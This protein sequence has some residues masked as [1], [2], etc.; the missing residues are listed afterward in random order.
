MHY[1]ATDEKTGLAFS[2]W[3]GSNEESFSIYTL[4]LQVMYRGVAV[5]LGGKESG[6]GQTMGP[7]SRPLDILVISSHR[8]TNVIHGTVS[9]G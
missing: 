7:R 8:P 6:V 1:G 9:R 4:H 5:S 2:H 3:I